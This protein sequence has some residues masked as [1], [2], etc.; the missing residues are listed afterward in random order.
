[1]YEWNKGVIGT[2][3]EKP[4][5]IEVDESQYYVYIRK[6]I[7]PYHHYEDVYE[8]EEEL[9]EEGNPTGNYN[10]IPTG[11][12]ELKFTGWKYDEMKV[13][14]D[15]WATENVRDLKLENESIKESNLNTMLALTEVFEMVLEMGL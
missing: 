9:D 3:S 2:Q 10:E 11:E 4:K 6:N 12:K 8:T 7:E 15:K 14:N 13:L 5:E 1:M